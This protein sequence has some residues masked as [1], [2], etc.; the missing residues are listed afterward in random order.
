MIHIQDSA[1]IISTL[2][3]HQGPIF[4]GDRGPIQGGDDENQT[5]DDST[6]YAFSAAV[7]SGVTSEGGDRWLRQSRNIATGGWRHA[8]SGA[9]CSVRRSDNTVLGN[10]GRGPVGQF[11]M[12]FPQ[13]AFPKRASDHA[14]ARVNMF[15]PGSG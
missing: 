1:G 6:I 2:F 10:R 3:Q 8:D 11:R 5:N 12:V 13:M 7:E 9:T 15:T 14:N 4:P